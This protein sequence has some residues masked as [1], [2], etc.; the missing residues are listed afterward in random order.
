VIDIRKASSNGQ[1]FTAALAA[2]G[3]TVAKGDR[4]DFV[5]ID[6]AGGSTAWPDSPT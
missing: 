4:R 2:Q 1:E 6:Q 3:Y 5:L